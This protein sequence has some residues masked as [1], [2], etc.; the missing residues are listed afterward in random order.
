[1][2]G[3]AASAGTVAADKFFTA[4]LIYKYINVYT[5]INTVHIYSTGLYV[6]LCYRHTLHRMKVSIL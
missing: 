1:M 4:L 2:T 3:E 6:Q 5:P